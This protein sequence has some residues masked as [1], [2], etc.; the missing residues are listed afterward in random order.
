MIKVRLKQESENIDT[1][2][3]KYLYMG[4]DVGGCLCQIHQMFSFLQLLQTYLIL[5]HTQ[6][7]IYM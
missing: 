6:S 5:D 3:M 2:E 7:K 1:N 4:T